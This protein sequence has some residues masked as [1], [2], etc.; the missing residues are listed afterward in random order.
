MNSLELMTTCPKTGIIVK[1][2]MLEKML[3]S[4]N[5]ESLP[6]N[7]KQFVREQGIDDEKL[8]VL[9]D[10]NPRALLDVFDNHKI[11]IGITISIETGCPPLYRYVHYSDGGSAESIDYPT[12]KDA[13]SAA[14]ENAFKI[15]NS[16]L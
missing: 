4:L 9:I 10:A 11:Y 1:Q 15:L 5:D 12:R 14:I 2:W 16:K 6:E 3:E 7:F 8:A 13:E